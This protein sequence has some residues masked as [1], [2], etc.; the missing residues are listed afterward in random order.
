ML[1]PAIVVG[2]VFVAGVVKVIDYYLLGGFLFGDSCSDPARRSPASDTEEP[3]P[4][5]ILFG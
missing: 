3:P 4:G 2:L 5:A 1:L